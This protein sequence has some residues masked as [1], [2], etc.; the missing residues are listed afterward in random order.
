MRHPTL[1][2]RRRCLATILLAAGFGAAMTAASPASEVNIYSYRQPHLI[3]PLLDSFTAATGIETRVL[4]L[5]QGLIER[6]RTEG[7]ASPADV[8]LTVDIGRLTAARREGVTRAVQDPVVNER[9]PAELRDPAG[10]WIGLTVR[11]RILYASRERTAP[12]DITAY[13]ALADP[14]WQGRICSRSGLHRYNVALVAA[15]IAHHGREATGSWLQGVRSN[16][17]RK[18]QGND[19]AQVK[20]IW[21]GECDLAIGNTY[22]MGLMLADPE[23]QEWARSVRVEFP[24]FAGGGTHVNI[25][26]V[27]MAKHAPNPDNALAL[28]R[29]L[30]SPEAQRIYAGINF[31]YPAD[32]EVAVSDIVAAWGTPERDT[33]SL[34]AIAENSPTA[35]RLVEEVGFDEGP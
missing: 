34:A 20:A 1:P 8:I 9:V 3:Q 23:Q 15:H 31:E 4:S 14:E 33:L 17:A 26:G 30:V 18:P 12:G 2:G 11:A 10:H 19:R 6:I 13:E 5:Q 7:E 25:S 27:A 32:P 21:A 28:I 29:F 22:Y 35:L 16:L 24:R